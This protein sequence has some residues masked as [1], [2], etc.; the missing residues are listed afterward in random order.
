[1][2]N[3]KKTIQFSYFSLF[4]QKR[5]LLELIFSLDLSIKLVLIKWLMN[6][7]HLNEIVP[8]AKARYRRMELEANGATIYWTER[9]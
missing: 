5:E 9:I 7:E 4:P 2:I 6:G 3:V 1:M 8:L